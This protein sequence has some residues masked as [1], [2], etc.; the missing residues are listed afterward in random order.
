MANNSLLRKVISTWIKRRQLNISGVTSVISSIFFILSLIGIFATTGVL[1]LMSIVL[2]VITFIIL[3]YEFFFELPAKA[4][5]EAQNR[6]AELL[7]LEQARK[8][9]E[10][11]PHLFLSAR[12][13]SL[14]IEKGM[15]HIGCDIVVASRLPFEI[16]I[17]KADVILWLPKDEGHRR[18]DMCTPIGE[19]CGAISGEAKQHSR[20]IRVY[21]Y[22][23][24]ELSGSLLDFLGEYP[25][26]Y[27]PCVKG[28]VII[29]INGEEIRL[30]IPETSIIV[31]ELSKLT[32][33]IGE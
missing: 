23:N 24:P 30:E 11:N 6:I 7:P 19:S 14:F 2:L 21:S 4:Y 8:Y 10:E 31:S 26:N 32:P 22:N 29:N 25:C 3:F 9:Q 12:V 17:K 15:P 16:Q 33:N 13:D 20:K 28:D 5:Q 27:L 18:C 1:H